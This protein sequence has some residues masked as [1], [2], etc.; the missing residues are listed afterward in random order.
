[1]WV[2]HHKLFVNIKRTD[3]LFLLL[4]GLLLMA[5][6]VVPFPTALLSEYIEHRDGGVAAAVYSGT[7]VITAIFFNLLWRYAAY[8]DRLL[9]E[10]HDRAFVR[11][12]NRQY[13]FGPLLYLVAFMLAFIS[14]AAS[15]GTCILL[16][17]FFALPGDP[18]RSRSRPL[19]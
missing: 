10:K 13:M 16:A 7:F 9:D 6:T 8:K 18:H 17:A 3:H 5:V 19:H 4:N 11:R 2:N 15:F 1:M 12:I 14:V